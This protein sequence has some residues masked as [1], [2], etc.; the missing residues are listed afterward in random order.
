MTNEKSRRLD[1]LDPRII[2]PSTGPLPLLR[3]W[4]HLITLLSLRITHCAHT[5]GSEFHSFFKMIITRFTKEVSFKHG[6]VELIGL[7]VQRWGS[8]WNIT[9]LRTWELYWNTFRIDQ[10]RIRP[11]WLNLQD[12]LKKNRFDKQMSRFLFPFIIVY[13]WNRGELT[14]NWYS[15]YFCPR[16]HVF[17]RYVNVCVKWRYSYHSENGGLSYSLAG[18]IFQSL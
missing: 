17:D 11:K 9:F 14:G 12:I 4:D 7:K 8:L 1:I 2:R 6:A 5:R 3:S 16:S 13:C 10:Y 15:N 18:G